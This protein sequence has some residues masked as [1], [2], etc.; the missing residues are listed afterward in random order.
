[1]NLN[2]QLFSVYDHCQRQPNV[3]Y[4]SPANNRQHQQASILKTIRSSFART[5]VS[6]SFL[7][8]ITTKNGS[9][10]GY[11]PYRRNDFANNHLFV[12]KHKLARLFLEQSTM[13]IRT[14]SD[15]IHL[16]DRNEQEQKNRRINKNKR[17]GQICTNKNKQ[18]NL[19]FFQQNN[20]PHSESTSILEPDV[21]LSV[22]NLIM[23]PSLSSIHTRDPLATI[24]RS[25]GQVINCQ[26]KA[27][28]SSI[29]WIN[30]A[31]EHHIR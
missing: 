18:N 24:S 22:V 14:R 3:G 27:V 1:M 29:K 17:E 21:H 8:S 31:I 6:E 19:V 28:R 20:N 4:R 11:K 9:N 30:P 25:R 5:N 2:T 7:P 26:T 13:D 16:F 23:K 10:D 15:L 12:T